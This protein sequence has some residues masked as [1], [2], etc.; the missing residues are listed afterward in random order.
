M[1][2]IWYRGS[3][4]KEAN[5]LENFMLHCLS[6]V[7]CQSEHSCTHGAVLLN[8]VFTDLGGGGGRCLQNMQ[9]TPS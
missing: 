4:Y 5:L 3:Y 8:I 2:E 6:V 9:P 1:K 7:N